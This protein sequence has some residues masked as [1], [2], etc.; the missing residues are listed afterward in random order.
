MR[1]SGRRLW[2]VRLP[3]DLL[4]RVLRFAGNILDEKGAHVGI[5]NTDEEVTTL[6][7]IFG[8]SIS[9]TGPGAHD[10]QLSPRMFFAIRHIEVAARLEHMAEARGRPRPGQLHPADAFEAWQRL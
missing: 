9:Y 4:W 1:E 7:E 8:D 10:E 2:R 6:Q 3:I 5:A